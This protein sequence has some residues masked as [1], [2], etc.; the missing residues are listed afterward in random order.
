MWHI[1]WSITVPQIRKVNWDNEE[2]IINIPHQNIFCDPAL[3]PS[4]RDGSNEGSQHM[5]LMRNKK[6]NL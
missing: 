5:F 2:I 6:K 3:E 1:I 4:H